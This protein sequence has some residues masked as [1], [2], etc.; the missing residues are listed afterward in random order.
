MNVT[1]TEVE[2]YQ[3]EGVV[4]LRQALSH[5]QVELL[6]EA[7]QEVIEQRRETALDH[8]AGTGGV[9]FHDVDLWKAM[10]EVRDIETKS[11]VPGIAAVLMKAKSLSLYGDHLLVKEP[12][13]P[14]ASTPWHQDEPYMRAAGTQM[15]SVWIALDRVTLDTGAMRFVRGSHKWG[16]LFRPVRF[17]QGEEFAQDRFSESVPDV[18]AD[19]GA[20]DIV[21]YDLEPGDCTVHHIRTLHCAGGNRSLSTRRRALVVRFAGEDA[22]YVG[23]SPNAQWPGRIERKAGDAL[24]PREFPT[25]AWSLPK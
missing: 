2:Q 1:E 9:F 25:V 19:P 8:A 3:R 12:G 4:F 20:Y 14:L 17:A 5:E 24:D 23:Q 16:K 10:P 7:A 13:S 11:A 15:V 6:R 21:S 22:R 18:D